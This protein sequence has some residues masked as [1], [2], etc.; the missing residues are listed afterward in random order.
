MSSLGPEAADPV[1][2][3]EGAGVPIYL[4]DEDRRIVFLN[5][6]CA[7]WLGIEAAAL[8]G[9]KCNYHTAVEGDGAPTVAAGLCPPPQVFSGHARSGLVSY[10]RPDG[11][12][13]YRRGHFL[14]LDDG[15]D[16]SSPVLAVLEAGDCKPDESPA[17][18]P[19]ETQLHEAVGRFRRQMAGRFA[20]DRLIGSSPAM[21]R[22][23]AQVRAAAGTA[24]HVLVSGPAGSGKDHT[25][26]AIH[27]GQREPGLLVP[28][29]CAVLETNVVRSALRTLCSRS[30]SRPAGSTL[31]LESVER[32][33]GEVQAEL[34]EML[35]DDRLQMRVVSTTIRPPAELS[36]EGGLLAELVYRLSTLVIELP[37]LLSRQEDLPL[38]VQAAVEEL[39]ASSMRQ[40]AGLRREAMDYLVAY[41]WPGNL[42][43]LSAV[44]RDVHQRS[45]GAEITPRDLPKQIYWGIDAAAH[46]PKSDDAIVLEEFLANV[47]KELIA[48]A[49]RRAKN[50]KSKAAKLLGL[51]RPRLYRRLVQLGLEPPKDKPDSP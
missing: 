3:L 13:V 23:R 28:M 21:T 45:R 40:V 17:D 7:A 5:A 50:N 36:G 46:P 16:E 29:D 6:P 25:A 2:L 10:A 44:V 14:P 48:R 38:L 8:I 18:D 27:Y 4:L 41:P 42:D 31:L 33:P 39:N 1:K 32:M 12:L 35:R 34:N 22:V 26:K 30:A 24:A 43:E 20:A 11:Q 15:A 51:T 49:M 9:Q 47:E 37:P 19:L